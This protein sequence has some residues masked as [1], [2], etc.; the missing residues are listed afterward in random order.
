MR[1]F[2]SG[3]CAILLVWWGV[4]G[5]AQAPAVENI[6]Y[7]EPVL[8]LITQC[9]LRQL[10]PRELTCE[11]DGWP[12]QVSL[13]KNITV[14]KG[15]DRRDIAALRGGDQLD[16]KLGLDAEGHEVATFI[17]ANLVKIEGV[18]GR[19]GAGK[20]ARIGVFARDHVVIEQGQRHRSPFR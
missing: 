13:S 15:Q 11:R 10:S 7:V 9:E 8:R 6:I 19:A 20:T 1:F 17:W 18:V 16:I 12:R 3:A 2:L 14:W 4:S 5:R